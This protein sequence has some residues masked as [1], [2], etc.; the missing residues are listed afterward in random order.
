MN[1]VFAAPR[2]LIIG[3]TTSEQFIETFTLPTGLRA[4]QLCA[5]SGSV[6]EASCTPIGKATGYTEQ[7]LKDRI[8][9]LQSNQTKSYVTYIGLGALGFAIGVVGYLRFAP[10]ASTHW[11]SFWETIGD[12]II[13]FGKPLASG[14]A[15]I[16][17]ASV[18]AYFVIDSR[19][20][21]DWTHASVSLGEKL[22]DE[23]PLVLLVDDFPKQV[24]ALNYVLMGL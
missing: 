18:G 20:W 1:P 3:K 11:G 17:V 16:G 19:G 22:V 12:A 13:T 21:F 10:A 6:K 9:Q 24:S 5:V 8:S 4:F 7:A 2:G 14:A 23:K 15:G